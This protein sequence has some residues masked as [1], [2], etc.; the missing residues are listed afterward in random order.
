MLLVSLTFC[1]SDQ[2]LLLFKF[3][4]FV[5]NI[6]LHCTIIT[7]YCVW[8]SN[9]T[10]GTALSCAAAQGHDMI[11]QYLLSSGASTL[12]GYHPENFKVVK[13]T[14][15]NIHCLKLIIVLR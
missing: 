9:R 11:V 4:I 14:F 5:L 8:F 13:L 2:S 10:E 1:S 12:G 15:T 3:K 7:F 6:L